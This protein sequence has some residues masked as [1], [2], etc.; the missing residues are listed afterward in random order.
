MLLNTDEYIKI[1]NGIKSQIRDAQYRAVLG[2]NSE[3]IKLYWGIG[4]TIN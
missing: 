4:N 1:V 3:M 2:A